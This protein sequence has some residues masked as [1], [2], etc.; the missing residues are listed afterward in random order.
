[1]DSRPEIVQRHNPGYHRRQRFRDLR[2]AHICDMILPVYREPVNF[3]MECRR[4]LAGGSGEI[5]RT[6]RSDRPCSP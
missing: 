4:H 6:C 2:I 5:N 1:M 3:R